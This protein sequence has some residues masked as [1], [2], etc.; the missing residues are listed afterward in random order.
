[1]MFWWKVEKESKYCEDLGVDGRQQWKYAIC[2]LKS[3]I[4][5]FE[6][7]NKQ[8]NKQTPWPQV[9]KQTIPSDRHLAKFSA[10]FC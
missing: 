3:V 2:R 6:Q 8:T 5:S 10:I 7:T 1:M 9:R 4:E